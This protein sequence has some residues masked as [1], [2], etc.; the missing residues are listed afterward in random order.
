[1]VTWP[2][3][4]AV[5]G[6]VALCCVLVYIICVLRGRGG[7]CQITHLSSCAIRESGIVHMACA[8]AAAARGGRASASVHPVSI[9]LLL[10]L[11]LHRLVAVA[12]ASRRAFAVEHALLLLLLLPGLAHTCMGLA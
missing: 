10:L 9:A 4:G 1:M 11:L 5:V 3:V 2:Y 12:A 8:A 6:L 7:A